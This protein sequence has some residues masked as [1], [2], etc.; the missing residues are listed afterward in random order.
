MRETNAPF[1]KQN[2]RKYALNSALSATSSARMSAAP[3]RASSGLVTSSER[4]FSASFSRDK[5]FA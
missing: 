1:F 4:Y 3:L 2:S 5:D